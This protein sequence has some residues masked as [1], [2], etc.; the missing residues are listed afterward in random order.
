MSFSK[1]RL[2]TVGFVLVFVLSGPAGVITSVTAENADPEPTVLNE[3]DT[4]IKAPD[5]VTVGES[6]T[7]SVRGENEGGPAGSYSTITMSFPSF[8]QSSDDAQITNV[9]HDFDT[10]GYSSVYTA[11]DTI[12]EKDGDQR[13]ASYALVEAGKTGEGT[14]DGSYTEHELSAEITPEQ[15]GTFVIYVRVTMPDDGDS[16]QKFNWPTSS[17][18]TDQQEYTVHRVTVDVKSPQGDLDVTA[19]DRNGY[20]VDDADVVLYDDSWN[21]IGT[22]TTDW[23]GDA[24]WSNI[25][26]GTYNLELYGPNGDYWGTKTNVDLDTGGTTTTIQRTAPLL[27]DISLTDQTNGD[28][29]F[30][31][32]ET[33]NIAPAVHNDGATRD[34]RVKI[35]VDTDNDGAAETSVTRGDRS[36]EIRSG[37][38]GYYGFDYQPSTAGTKQVRVVTETYING[39]WVKTDYSGWTKTITV[40]PDTGD[41]SVSATDTAGNAIENANVVLFDDNWNEVGTKT[42][43]WSGDVTWSDLDTGTYNLELYGP[44]GA[45]W[46]TRT[47]VTVDLDGTST[48]IERT[49]PRLTDIS[50]TDQTNGDGTYVV[51][52][53]V[54]IAPT[55]R[56]DGARRDVRVKIKVDTDN[57]NT[58]EDTI[59]RGD[60]STEIANSDVRY[61]G[62][63]YQPSL[64]GPK[65]VRVITEAYVSGGWIVTDYS[66]WSKTFDVVADEGDLAVSATTTTGEGV[67]DGTVVLYDDSSSGW[68]ELGEKALGSEGQVTW[69]DLDTGTYNLELYGPNGAYWGTRTDVTVDLDETSTTIERTAPRLTDVTL[70]DQTNGD[71]IFVVGETINIAPA[72]RNDGAARDVRVRIKV[73][74]DND[75]V[76]ETSV[77]RGGQSTEISSGATDYYG[78]DYQPSTA[79]TKQVSVV[80]EAYLGDKWVVTDYSGWSKAFDVVSDEG[81]LTVSATTTAGNTISDGTVVLY[82][83]NSNGWSEIGQ[84][85]LDSAD[86]ASWPGLDTGSYNLELYGPNGA[87]WG[88]RTDVSVD[89]N[90]TNTTIERTAPRLSDISLTDQTNGDGTYVVGETVN[91]A[92]TVRNDGARRDVRVTIDVDTDSDGAAEQ[93]VRRGDRTTDIPSNDVGYYGY[94][95]QS[96]SAGTKQVRVVTETYVNGN[97]TVTDYSGWSK[98][99]DVV[100]DEGPLTVS[101]TDASGAPVS[102][103][104][105]VLYDD[106]ADGWTELQRLDTGTD[107]VVSWSELDTGTYNV[108]LYGPNGAYWGTQTD[109]T[110]DRNGTT[111]AIQRQTP[112]VIAVDVVAEN[113]TVE[114]GEPVNITTTVRNDGPRPEL[115][116]R[117]KIHVDT[118][119]DG[120][121]NAVLNRAGNDSN[122]LARD[123]GTHRY[124]YTFTPDQIGTKNIRII[125]ESY[126]NGDWILTGDTDWVKSFSLT[127]GSDV[128]DVGFTPSTPIT[129]ERLVFRSL[130]QNSTALETSRWE[131]GDGATATG[132]QVAHTYSSPGIY[133]VTHE[134]TTAT[135]ESYIS[136]SEITVKEQTTEPYG[137]VAVT[138]HLRGDATDD[139]TLLEGTAVDLRYRATVTN[140]SK[141]DHV[142]F[143]YGNKTYTDSDGSD[144]WSVAIDSATLDT[145]KTV[146]A[147]AVASDGTTDR[148]AAQLAVVQTPEWFESFE[149]QNISTDR[150]VVTYQATIPEDAGQTGITTIPDK[151]PFGTDVNM[152]GVGSGQ[153]TEVVVYLIMSV[154]LA[155]AESETTVTGN[156]NYE[157]QVVTVDGNVTGTAYADLAEGNL[158]DGRLYA[159]ATTTAEYPPPPTGIP[160]PPIGPVPP[161]VVSI[162]PVFEAELEATANFDDVDA[163]TTGPNFKF[164]NGVLSPRLEARQEV[165][166]KYDSVEL[167]VGFEEGIDTEMPMANLSTVNGS[168]YGQLYTRADLF[169]MT[170]QRSYPG[171]E[172]RF[173]YTFRSGEKANT[174]GSLTTQATDTTTTQW[175]VQQKSGE[176]PPAH[177]TGSKLGT[178]EDTSGVSANRI[179][180]SGTLTNDTVT[181]ASASLATRGSIPTVVWSRQNPEKSVLNGRDIYVSE[182]S[183]Q[184][185]SAGQPLTDDQ[186]ADYDPSIAGSDASALAAFTTF[187]KTFDA[188]AVTGPSDLFAHGEIRVATHDGTRWSEPTQL[189]NNSYLD[190]QP[191]VAN[192]NGTYLIA[193]EQD[194]DGNL[195]TWQDRRVQYVTYDGQAS[196][197]RTIETARSPTVSATGESFTLATV[198]MGHSRTNG[199]VV[200]RTVDSTGTVTGTRQT[201]VGHLTALDS[202]NG[203]VAWLD[204]NS[205]TPLHI[206]NDTGVTA[207][208]LDSNISTP[209]A[210][211]LTARDNHLLVSIRAHTESASVARQFY[212]VRAN[213]HWL[214]ARLYADGSNKNLTFWQGDSV[215]T[216][217]GFV[218]V[219]AGKELLT[220]QKQDLY[221][222]R[223]QFRPDLTVTATPDAQGQSVGNTTTLSVRV[224]NKGDIPSEAISIVLT[225]GA[226]PIETASVEALGPGTDTTIQL[227]GTVDASGVLA[228]HVDPDNNLTEFSEENNRDTVKLAKPDLTV[229]NLRAAR[230]NKTVRINATVSNP[231]AVRA[232][233][234]TATVTNGPNV[235]TE[236]P[237]PAIEPRGTKTISFSVPTVDASSAYPVRIRVDSANAVA[238][239]DEQNNTISKRV[240]RPDIELSPGQINYYL[241]NGTVTAK[242]LIENDGLATGTGVLAVDSLGE[243]RTVGEQMFSVDSTADTTTTVFSTVEIPLEGVNESDSLQFV[244]T[245]DDG[246]TP[247]DPVAVDT[248]ELNTTLTPPEATLELQSQTVEIGER[249]ILRADTDDIDGNVTS[250][251]WNISGTTVATN[252]TNYTWTP[253]DL[254]P[255]TIR[256]TVVDDDGLST[257]ITRNVVVDAKVPTVASE[258]DP[259]TDIDAD[260]RYEDVNGDG[261]FNIVDVQALFANRDNM[262]NKTQQLA[263]D[264]TGNGQFDIVDI[265]RLFRTAAAT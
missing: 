260:G 20:D 126:I 258:L 55:V 136:T 26:T 238:E 147:T 261:E 14:W 76:A 142:T 236:I 38:T 199:S 203:T 179:V 163:G 214:P 87:Y 222:F 133:T 9:Q 78:Y 174:Q 189:T 118:D 17:S 128:V 123:G 56:N 153:E 67:G 1:T 202:A 227:Q 21:E 66:G 81:P 165:G 101:T 215:S 98:A 83:D 34:V 116:V 176:R 167:I 89:L 93:T 28:G 149:L 250:V 216:A 57:D 206:A 230:T 47:D 95:F 30:V 200:T 7:I 263:F 92:P 186:Y 182:S 156:V 208:Q 53:T 198:S 184:A 48:T 254:G 112:H 5:E 226:T 33:V 141:T 220:D 253:S 255:H 91:I 51:G 143:A 197:I 100:A 122:Q 79:G 90:G 234:T 249:T 41:L 127:Q 3:S 109:V 75:D 107:G 86:Q 106:T 131:F 117:V 16:S 42:S 137:I 162:Y 154:D 6:F 155:T 84:K 45:Y 72:V 113:E 114:V 237:V 110:I 181:D 104:T 140:N 36:T 218:S 231:T 59:V 8:D 244:A 194:T 60:R 221:V 111:V 73:D 31:V 225:N 204:V 259:A 229:E 15:T 4:Y 209:Q 62:Y 161:N 46:G 201:H 257:V 102:G 158:T 144:G 120:Q 183:D 135:G 49:A 119:G 219:F 185:F 191:V 170:T 248:V 180:D 224:E 242:V 243:D 138:P 264:F 166:K 256:L 239:R 164:T 195:S 210:I 233:P 262:S 32:D 61:Y 18:Y 177:P 150:G 25:D 58:A 232:P 129:D 54:N 172:D 196:S 251:E 99:F 44:N 252:Q 43:D 190:A 175:S 19:E 187:T 173:Q 193:W 105:V 103:G 12:T 211:D 13:T 124:G 223:Q 71:G 130:V 157:L 178:D 50:L 146:V 207:I 151:F 212:K 2:F 134:V 235:T 80:S 108:E 70:T 169:G 68:T 240:F 217:D 121:M 159:R 37:D 10:N 125:T 228:V 188:N 192:S 88:T 152:P 35:K 241:S 63:D 160:N 27:T 29:T 85:T 132:S 40:I 247:Q 139:I 22:K 148:Q 65:Q 245:V 97:W 52:E 213:G 94:D 265:Q 82:N 96:S 246:A 171:G 168:V 69:S 205:T 77:V 24:S 23:S 145:D 11:G 74:T 115:P 64:A 39:D